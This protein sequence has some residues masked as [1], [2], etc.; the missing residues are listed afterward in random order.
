VA[1]REPWDDE[2]LTVYG[3]LME[4][5]HAL[6]AEFE[7][8]V[9]SAAGVPVMWFE[10]LLR[11]ARSPDQ[12]LRMNELARQVRMSTSG[13]TR[14]F[15]RME[16]ADLVR[17]QV[18]PSDRRGWMAVLTG[19]GRRVLR[20]GLAVHVPS[21]ERRIVGPLGD[22]LPVLEDLLRRLRDG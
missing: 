13:L 6:E 7:P 14:L 19:S 2:R 11:L 4:A 22:D 21:L 8:E 18:C 17:R 1:E 3:L 9:E 20:K 15:D 5:H 12:Q 16:E 10:V